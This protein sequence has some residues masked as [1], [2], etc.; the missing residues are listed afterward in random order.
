MLLVD[1]PAGPTSHDV[2]DAV[3]RALGMRRVGHAGTLDP[4]ATGLLVVL[5]GRA[6]R[7]ARFI[8]ML[9]KRYEGTVRFGFETTTDDAAGE[10]AER[11]PGWTA[12][13][14]SQIEAALA[15][16]AAQPLQLPPPVSAKKVDG[17]RAYR[18]A[19][20]GEAPVMKPVAVT[21]HELR[22]TGVDPATGEAAIA[23]ACSS[24]TYVRAIARDLGRALG[25]RAHLAALRRTAIGAWRVEEAVS[26]EAL[27]SGPPPLRP[28][29][30]AVAHLPV[31]EVGAE[32]GRRFRT[33]R[34]LAA[35]AVPAGP[36]GFV[37]VVEDGQLL[38]VGEC[39]DEGC[40]P[41]V[42]LAS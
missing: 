12:R 18:L 10:P 24:G 28:M 1:K 15:H 41:V 17:E 25:T 42:G 3:R 9:P 30:E 26:L 39:R 34:P 7:L 13:T 31:L 22:L 40:V 11:D 5:A 37:A 14:P 21:I 6:T 35:P 2:V 4:G 23:V 8:A 38:G 29:G 19:R 20:R 27:A 36:A 32:E 16:V 33:G